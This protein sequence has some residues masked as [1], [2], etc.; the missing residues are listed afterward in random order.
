MEARENRLPLALLLLRLSVFL[1]MLM[2]TLDK[3]VN[4]GHA[5]KVYENFYVLGGLG[6][7]FFWIV[8]LLELAIIGGFVL[9]VARTITYGTVLVLHAISTFSAYRQY[10][11][12]FDNLLF[13][14]AWP[15]L[16]AC[17]ALF[18]LRDEDVL[19]VV[20]RRP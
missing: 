3:F 7:T 8:G 14:T 4:P 13:F 20:S 5:S 9:G 16:A 12:P 6:T 19:W 15:M 17:V 11:D 10:L 18:L 2:W 1:V